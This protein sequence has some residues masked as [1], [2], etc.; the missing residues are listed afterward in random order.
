MKSY[1]ESSSQFKVPP[2]RTNKV[3]PS[4]QVRDR[5]VELVTNT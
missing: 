3:E 2:S 1:R 5:K 4:V